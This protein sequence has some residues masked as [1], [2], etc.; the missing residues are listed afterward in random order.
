MNNTQQGNKEYKKRTKVQTKDKT[1][2]HK[3]H[4][5]KPKEEKPSI[6]RITSSTKQLVYCILPYLPALI[7]YRC[8]ISCGW[9]VLTFEKWLLAPPPRP[10]TQVLPPSPKK[11]T[12]HSPVIMSF[13]A[14]DHTPHGPTNFFWKRIQFM[15]ARWWNPTNHKLTKAPKIRENKEQNGRTY[16]IQED[17]R[18]T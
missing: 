17:K 7:S 16:Y 12:W 11:L 5:R 14:C 15:L 1:Q 3:T 10:D 13:E 8:N 4:N 6:I 18:T 2:K 9:L